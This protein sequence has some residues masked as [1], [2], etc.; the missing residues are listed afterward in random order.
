MST[1]QPYKVVNLADNTVGTIMDIKEVLDLYWRYNITGGN[2]HIIL[3]DG[4]VH[5]HHIEFCMNLC[6]EKGDI[7]GLILLSHLHDLTPTERDSW[8]AS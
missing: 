8:L 2:L 6:E 7:A 5:D 3:D 4:N 1:V